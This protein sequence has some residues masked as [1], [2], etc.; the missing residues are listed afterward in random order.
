M[1]AR[2]TTE[3]LYDKI[4]AVGKDVALIQQGQ[5]HQHE[6]NELKLKQHDDR[7]CKL[8]DGLEK[9]HDRISRVEK[10]IDAKLDALLNKFDVNEKDASEKTTEF[11]VEITRLTMRVAGI[12]SLVT[13]IIGAVIGALV[14]KWIP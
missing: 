1:G 8:E 3:K 10:S 9:V 4:D 2:I 6:M 13:M 11:K 7:L 5:A 12:I 14:R